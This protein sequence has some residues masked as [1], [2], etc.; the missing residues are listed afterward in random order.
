MLLFLYKYFDV[1]YKFRISRSKYFFLCIFL[2]IKRVQKRGIW[3]GEDF[4]TMRFYEGPPGR[5]IMHYS[6][7]VAKLKPILKKGKKTDPSNY[8]PTSLLPAI[9]KT[10]EK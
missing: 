8:R 7:K 10:I 2:T 4:F 3:K 5:S 9:S 1:A 6:C